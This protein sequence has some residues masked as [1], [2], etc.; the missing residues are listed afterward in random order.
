MYILLFLFTPIIIPQ[1]HIKELLNFSVNKESDVRIHDIS[2]DGF[3]IFSEKR[4]ENS[5]FY[6]IDSKEKESKKLLFTTPYNRKNSINFG[7]GNNIIIFKTVRLNRSYLEV[8]NV[9]DSS[10][11]TIVHP[12]GNIVSANMLDEY[13]LLCQ[14]RKLGSLAKIY[15]Y[16]FEDDKWKYITNGIGQVCSPNNNWFFVKVPDPVKNQLR[17]DLKSGRIS[18]KEYSEKKKNLQLIRK[19]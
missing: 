5:N 8:L 10:I 14:V 3:I 9:T 19:D 1:S 2:N 13:K 12:E 6:L 4:N 16:T 17:E 15:L 18:K 11:R 7:R